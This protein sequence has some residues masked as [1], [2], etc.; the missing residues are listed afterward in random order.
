MLVHPGS[1]SR[2]PTPSNHLFSYTS[3]IVSLAAAWN[4]FIIAPS[5]G[6]VGLA[7]LGGLA[8]W[9]TYEYMIGLQALGYLVLARFVWT[10]DPGPAA[11]RRKRVIAVSLPFLIPLALF[12]VYRLFFFE[13]GRGA[14]DVGSVLAAYQASPLNRG[15]AGRRAQRGLRQ[16]VILAGPSQPTTSPSPPPRG[17]PH[18]PGVGQWRAG[19]AGVRR[20]S[21]RA[22][23]NHFRCSRSPLSG[24]RLDRG[25]HCRR[26]DRARHP[27]RPRHPLGERF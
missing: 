13:A 23:I 17:H 14:V 3:A 22:T 27:R 25:V 6:Y 26:G 12:L 15:A 11:Q 5:A 4:R 1:S 19:I 2:T 18:R 7:V 9:L 16:A 20:W 24:V 10:S 8:S 21:D